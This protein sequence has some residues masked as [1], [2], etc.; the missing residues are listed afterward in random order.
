MKRWM[1]KKLLTSAVKVRP[2]LV[3]TGRPNK[4]KNEKTKRQRRARQSLERRTKT[5]LKRTFM[6]KKLSNIK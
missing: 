2:Q 3:T 5:G 6:P 4:I 1:R